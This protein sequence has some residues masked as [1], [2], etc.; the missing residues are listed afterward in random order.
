M[1][2]YE[3]EMITFI[4]KNHKWEIKLK[5][6]KEKPTQNSAL[7]Q[8]A[9]V[10]VIPDQSLKLVHSKISNGAIK[11]LSQPLFTFDP[12]EV[13]QDEDFEIGD[14]KFDNVSKHFRIPFLNNTGRY[15]ILQRGETLGNIHELQEV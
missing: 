11:K 7:V 12:F 5:Y 14:I 9:K 8:I 13:V 15:I 6:F 10:T 1:R 3:N 2:D 4:P